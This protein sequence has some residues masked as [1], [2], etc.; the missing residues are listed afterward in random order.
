MQEN[1]TSR[2]PSRSRRPPGDLSGSLALVTGATAGIGRAIVDAIGSAGATVV[3]TSR[4]EDAVQNTVQELAS[5]GIEAYGWPADVR[6]EDD[7]RDLFGFV[8][9]LDA[10]LDILVN[11]AGGSFGDEFQRG[12]LRE[13]TVQDLTE[14]FRL[15]VASAFLCA[16]SAVELMMDRGGVI[17]N[18]SSISG[19]RS[20]SP[21]MGAYGACKAALNNLTKSMALEWAPKVRVNA[22]APGFIDTAR[23]SATRTPE[24]LEGQLRTV[25]L[26]RMGTPDEVA[27]LVRYLV[28]PGAAWTTG[29]VYELDGGFKSG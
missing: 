16:T 14:T 24:R 26:G 11:S 5:A 1:T 27:S 29:V 3:V 10:T 20:G 25:A 23:T 6:D 7:V 22:V 8:G 18:V 17:V 4:H 28:S 12:P 13:I 19:V 2:L 9:G 21:G 15:N